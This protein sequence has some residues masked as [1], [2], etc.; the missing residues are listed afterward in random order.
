MAI[1]TVP[2]DASSI[3]ILPLRSTLSSALLRSTETPLPSRLRVRSVLTL[4]CRPKKEEGE[5]EQQLSTHQEAISLEM[6]SMAAMGVLRFSPA[7]ESPTQKTLAHRIS[8]L[9]FSSSQLSG[10]KIAASNAV[11]AA[12]GRAPIVV[13]PKAVSDSRNSQTCLDPDASRVSLFNR[14]IRLHYCVRDFVCFLLS[15]RVMLPLFSVIAIT[16]LIEF[17]GAYL[18]LGWFLLLSPPSFSLLLSP[19]TCWCNVSCHSISC[20]PTNGADGGAKYICCQEKFP[21]DW[22]SKC[23]IINFMNRQSEIIL[24]VLKFDLTIVPT[25][26]DLVASGNV[27]VW[28]LPSYYPETLPHLLLLRKFVV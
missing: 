16:G 13:S 2:E 12:S 17:F 21:Y 7:S 1:K 27:V 11:R 24:N 4:T 18:N 25:A 3:E 22:R 9:S 5:E 15:L 28:G 6:A 23:L 26:C 10:D 19:S 8:S 14:K 20:E